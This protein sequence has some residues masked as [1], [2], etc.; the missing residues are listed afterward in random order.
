MF[1]GS[2]VNNFGVQEVLDALVDLAPPPQPRKSSLVVN[3]QP[4][5]KTIQPEMENFSG[6]VF[7]VQANMDPATATASPLCACA[8]AST[9]R[10]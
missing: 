5:E 1:F 2:A 10:A 6:V 7:K 9:R 8:R 4:V 3:K